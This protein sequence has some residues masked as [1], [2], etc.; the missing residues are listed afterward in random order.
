MDL[1]DCFYHWKLDPSLW[2]FMGVQHPV[3]GQS[4]VFA[5][6]PMGF[7]LSPP[8]CCANT[9]FVAEIIEAEMRARFH[10]KASTR[11]AFDEVPR[12]AQG[13]AGVEPSSDVYV[14][15]FLHSVPSDDWVAEL[16]R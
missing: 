14:D 1:R 3:T 2:T 12:E 6:L 9:Q 8:I 11:A 15:D 13:C 4:Y 7:T 16:I 5:A 10:G